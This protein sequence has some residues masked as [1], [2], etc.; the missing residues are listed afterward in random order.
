L[1]F[2]VAFSA[3]KTS[4]P[5]RIASP[6]FGAP[7]GRIMKSWMSTLLSACAP[8]LTMFIIGSGSSQR[9]AS[10]AVPRPASQACNGW[11]WLAAAALAAASDTASK[12]L[13]PRRDLPGIP[14]SSI[15]D[16][17]SNH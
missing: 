3:W 2:S 16:S 1:A 9:P 6:E 8:P 4:A 12:A 17:A 11:R 7:T 5:K 15:I 14:S 10:G 13:A